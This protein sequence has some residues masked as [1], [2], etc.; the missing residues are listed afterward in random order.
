MTGG[1]E[2]VVKRP[3]CLNK[4]SVDPKLIEKVEFLVNNGM[5]WWHKEGQRKVKRLRG[6]LVN[7]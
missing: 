6:K 5:A 3:K 2:D 1:V 7:F 4:L